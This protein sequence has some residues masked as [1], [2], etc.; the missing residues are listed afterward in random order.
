MSNKS[1]VILLAAFSSLFGPLAA[2]A[3]GRSYQ[4]IC[5]A[6]AAAL[7]DASHMAVAS[8]DFSAIMIYQRG[9]PKPVTKFPLDD[10]TDIEGAARI[11]DTIFWLTSHSLNSSGQ[12]KPKRKELFATAVSADG[13]LSSS[14]E[15][16]RNL[17]AD[18]AAALK[19]S[20]GDLKTH[21]NIEGLAAT[22]EGHLL[23]GLRGPVPDN[24]AIVLELANPMQLVKLGTG[25]T[26]SAK[27]TQ[28]VTMDLSDG[29]GT[30]GRGV[31]DIARVGNRYLV[32]A[33]SEP[34]GG[35]PPPK[36]FWWDGNADGRV[37]SGPD[38]DFSGM[39]PEAIVVWNDH[40]GE[41][42]SDSG[43]AMIKGVACADKDP[44]KDAFFPAI[45]VKF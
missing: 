39:T 19:L 10:V 34:D 22:S 16:Y 32:L 7:V 28:V 43:G 26:G 44:P 30:T 40:E 3:A 14:G 6:S 37:T 13:T 38:A 8:D 17:R 9:K 12:D 23:I 5:E 36:L 42:L 31:R 21:V 11:G 1:R 15:V 29:P 4:G 27:M 33:G 18:M 41:I 2:N 20:E 45:D 35:N 25:D 24:R